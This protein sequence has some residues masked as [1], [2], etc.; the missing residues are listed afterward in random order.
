MS[1][2]GLL[3]DGQS[4]GGH[5]YSFCLHLILSAPA[6]VHFVQL[7]GKFPGLL[8]QNRRPLAVCILLGIAPLFVL[9]F[10]FGQDFLNPPYLVARQRHQ[11][12]V[13]LGLGQLQEVLC[14]LCNNFLLAS[15]PFGTPIAVQVTFPVAVKY[16]PIWLCGDFIRPKPSVLIGREAG[17]HLLEGIP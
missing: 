8:G 5:L 14:S 7:F 2:G 3:Q 15:R 9:S 6:K 16:T 17:H 12:P 1:H 4:H 13:L 11:P 10:P